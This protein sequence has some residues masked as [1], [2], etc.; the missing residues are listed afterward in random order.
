MKV[1]VI[2]NGG[3]EHAITW[4]LS[5]SAR[6]QALYVAPGNAGTAQLATN[7]PIAAND[8]PALVRFAKEQQI[9][10]TVVGP[11]D[12]LAAGCV[13]EFQKAGLKIFGVEKSA[14]RLEASKSFAKD[15]MIR[16][17]IPTARYHVCGSSREAIAGLADFQYPVV[18]K[19]DGLALGKGVIIARDK[20]EAHQAIIQIMD[21]RK[22]GAAG[23]QVVLEEFLTGFECSVHALVDGKQYL[24]FPTA[25]DHKALYDGNRGP[26]TG[27]MGTFSP[28]N[29]LNDKLIESIKHEILDS[30]VRGIQAD[31]INFRGLLFPGLML[32]DSGI[33]VLEFN[34]RFGDPETQVLLPRLESDLVDLLEATIE[35]RLDQVSAQWRPETAVCVILASGGYPA[36]YETGKPMIGLEEASQMKKVTLFHA[37]TRLDPNGSTTTAGGRVLGVTALAETMPRAKRLAYDA[38]EK[39]EF[40]GRYFRTDIGSS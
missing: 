21:E 12:T 18:I 14:A 6:I 1:L 38:V 31:Q 13:D 24:M 2:G 34:C 26:N 32:T 3:R 27:G 4:K 30:F 19:A 5:Q 9:D 15:F 36:H 28:S 22:F 33:K 16:H 35:Q 17:G 23:N 11:D 10:L 7:V 40:D 29:K 39:I 37:G 20:T 25:Q 8:I